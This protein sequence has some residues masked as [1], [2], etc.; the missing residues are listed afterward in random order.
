MKRALISVSNKEGVVDFARGLE[1]LGYQLISTGGTYTTL[2]DAGVQVTKV[3]EVTGFPEILDGRVKTLHPRVHGGILALRNEKHLAELEKNQIE[4]IDIVAVNLY[5]FRET[6]SRPGVTMGEAIENI[7]IGGPSMVRSAAKN[8]RHV[9]VVVKPAFYP[10]VLQQLQQKGDVDQDLRLRLALEAFTHTAAYDSMISA[11]LARLAGV[12]LDD[13]LVVAGE[14]VYD[15]RYGENPHQRA[16]FYRDL[17]PS[18]GLAD[19]QQL[20]GKE[21]SY[22]NIIDAEAAW[23]LVREFEEPACVIIKHTNPCGTAVASRLDEAY[24]RAFACDPL[25]AYGGI[26]AFNR[27]VDVETARKAAVPFM[28]VIIAPAYDADA[29]EIFTVKKNLRLL[30]LAMTRQAGWQLRSVE[31]GFVV[32]ETDQEELDLGNLQVATET[33]PTPEQM[34]ELK[35]AWKVVKHVKS[36]AIVVAR[37]RMTVGVGAGQMNR[38]GSAAIAFE[39]GG[40]KCQGAVLASDAYLPF[41]DTAELAASHGIKAIIQPGGSIHDQ[42]SID[43]CNRNGIAMVFTGVRHFKH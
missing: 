30:Q 31:G 40:E 29:L 11:Y 15:L 17:N 37:D 43:A 13:N 32:Q 10:V 22:N 4:P 25:S 8:Y 21:L 2:N 26:I 42:E 23:A 1:K 12:S 41:A 16:G 27:P 5:P 19:A 3:S 28:E 7:D 20:N 14:K 35:F 18:P 39:Q 6:I 34:E 24:E 33:A 36:N 38:V 9:V